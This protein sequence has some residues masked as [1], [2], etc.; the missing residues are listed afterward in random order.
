MFS[1]QTARERHPGVEVAA[2]S[3][4]ESTVNTQ[5]FPFVGLPG[6]REQC[7]GSDTTVMARQKKT[8]AARGSRHLFI[9][10]LQHRFPRQREAGSACLGESSD[11]FD[12]QRHAHAAADAQRGQA[13]AGFAALHFMQQRHQHAATGRP[14]RVTQRDRAAIDVHP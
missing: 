11:A 1:S 13:L 9:H 2:E 6:R 12:R 3:I 5:R 4:P 14:D 8:A 7:C 10:T